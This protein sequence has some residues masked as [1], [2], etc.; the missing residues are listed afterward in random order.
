DEVIQRRPEGRILVDFANTDYLDSAALGMLL[1]LRD[2][3]RRY[4]RSVV[5]A[6]ASGAVR[7]VLNIANFSKLFDIR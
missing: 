7:D 4:G 5:L 2:R 1:I 3:A 6:S